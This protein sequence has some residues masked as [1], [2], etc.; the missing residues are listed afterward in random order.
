MFCFTCGRAAGRELQC[1]RCSGRWPWLLFI[2]V[3][4]YPKDIR[5]LGDVRTARIAA[6]SASDHEHFGAN[7]RLA[8]EPVEQ[9]APRH[10]RQVRVSAVAERSTQ[11]SE[12]PLRNR[13]DG[14]GGQAPFATPKMW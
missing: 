4:R 1:A 8:R 5:E 9:R 10:G 7:S 14:A 6:P 3:S 12:K 11:P 13:G 2:I